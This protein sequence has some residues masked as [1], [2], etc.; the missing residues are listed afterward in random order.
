MTVLSADIYRILESDKL[1]MKNN[2]C[3]T[4]HYRQ[5]EQTITDL[6]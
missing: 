6:Y 1:A 5:K 4:T 3:Q 2:F